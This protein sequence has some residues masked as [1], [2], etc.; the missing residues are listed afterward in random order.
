MIA[1]KEK[2]REEARLQKERDERTR[3][4]GKAQAALDEA[5]EAHEGAM[6][7]IEREREKLDRR[8][9]K[10]TERWEAQRQKLSQA[11]DRARR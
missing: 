6:A 9:D 7:T 11:V 5:R 3:A 1:S 8:A 4:T 10:E 2:E